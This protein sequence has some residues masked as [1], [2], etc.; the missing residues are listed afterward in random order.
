MM[1]HHFP[2]SCLERF[3]SRDF[4]FLGNMVFD[5]GRKPLESLFED[6]GSLLAILDHEKVF[7]A[8]IE[9]SSPVVISPDLYFFVLVRRTLRDAGIED[10]RISDYVAATLAVHGAIRPGSPPDCPDI[11]FTYHVDV[12]EALD[13]ASDY[14]RFFV[15]VHCGNQFLV[16]TGLFPGFLAYRSERR[17]APRVGYYEELARMSFLSAGEHPLADEF[18]LRRLYPRLAD[19]LPETRCALNRMAEEFLCLGR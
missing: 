6:P 19:C 16:L 15:Q 7:H 8:I 10:I 9:M 14:D 18:D 4:H 17:G 5:S 13:G 11:D 12:L 1:T 3:T 2:T